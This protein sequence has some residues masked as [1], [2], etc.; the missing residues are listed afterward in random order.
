MNVLTGPRSTPAQTASLLELATLTE[1]SLLHTTDVLALI[2]AKT[3]YRAA[4]WEVCPLAV[5]DVTIAES[6]GLA[7]EDI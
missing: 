3:L 7:V 2:D 6:Y 1:L 4:G 5:A